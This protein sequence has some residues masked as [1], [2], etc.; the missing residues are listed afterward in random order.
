MFVFGKK[1]ADEGKIFDSKSATFAM[2]TRERIL[3][4]TCR[5]ERKI[6]IIENVV[7]K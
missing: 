3:E 1:N 6:E 4:G 2:M 7:I 5:T